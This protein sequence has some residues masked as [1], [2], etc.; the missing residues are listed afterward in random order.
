MT[1]EQIQ[2]IAIFLIGLSVASLIYE[3]AY[4]KGK[5]KREK[6][7]I[8]RAKLNADAICA[9]LNILTQTISIWG[10]A[11]LELKA[12]V[13]SKEEVNHGT[14]KQST[15]AGARDDKEELRNE[16][17]KAVGTNTKEK[18]LSTR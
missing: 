7:K 13:I 14:Q 15:H 8:L 5:A 11:I 10:K 9:Q 12:K 2:L 18:N 1:L 17:S 3:I 16:I 6:E 4:F